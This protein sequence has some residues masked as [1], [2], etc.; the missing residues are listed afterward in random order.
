MR[1]VYTTYPAKINQLLELIT[2]VISGE[3]YKS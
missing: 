2:I 3:D 1:A